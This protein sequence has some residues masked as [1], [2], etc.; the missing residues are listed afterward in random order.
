MITRKTLVIAS[1]LAFLVA[2][3][4]RAELLEQY[5]LFNLKSNELIIKQETKKPLEKDQ[6]VFTQ[7][8]GS[9]L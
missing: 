8:K 5:K 3:D 2:F 9:T 1:Y 4:Y 7:V 6:L